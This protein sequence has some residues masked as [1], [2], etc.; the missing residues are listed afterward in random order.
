ME[1]MLSIHILAERT[2]ACIF[3]KTQRDVPSSTYYIAGVRGLR[4][5]SRGAG[6]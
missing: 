3:S 4:S 6:V 1:N 2:N 5:A